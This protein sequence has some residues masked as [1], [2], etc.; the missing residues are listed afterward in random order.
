MNKCE[1]SLVQFLVLRLVRRSLGFHRLL[2]R[3]RGRRQ[4]PA[5]RGGLSFTR[6][7]VLD[8]ERLLGLGNVLGGG[9]LLVPPP[10][11]RDCCHSGLA[12]RGIAVRRACGLRDAQR[13]ASTS[14]GFPQ[15]LH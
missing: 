15:R 11:L 7:F 4:L 8:N 2:P 10:A 1:H 14:S 5:N 13:Q 12:R 3:T 9:F 6:L